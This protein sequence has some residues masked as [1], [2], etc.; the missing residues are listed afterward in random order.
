MAPLFSLGT[1]YSAT[2]KRFFC[3]KNFFLFVGVI[4]AGSLT[5]F[6]LGTLLWGLWV[7]KSIK[8]WPNFVGSFE[9]NRINLL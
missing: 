3:L 1:D 4:V 5:C 6:F 2:A 9:P 7:K 8:L